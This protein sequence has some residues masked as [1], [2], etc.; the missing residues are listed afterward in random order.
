MNAFI[1]GPLT[2]ESTI[3]A[4]V[5][6]TSVCMC[7]MYPHVINSWGTKQK[8]IL[9]PTPNIVALLQACSESHILSGEKIHYMEVLSQAQ[10]RTTLML[11]DKNIVVCQDGII[12][13]A[14]VR[15]IN[16]IAR[17]PAALITNSGVGGRAI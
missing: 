12:F 9:S 7:T 11:C 6:T 17:D 8:F 10:Y 15:V 14:T 5:T 1:V 16:R 4:T 2:Y 3:K 13:S